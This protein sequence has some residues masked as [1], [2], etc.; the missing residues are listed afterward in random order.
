MAEA[1]WADDTDTEI[2]AWT[3]YEAL[4]N[5]AFASSPATLMCTYDERSFPAEVIADARRTHPQLAYGS[6]ATASPSYRKPEDFL[7]AGC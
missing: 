4:V 3:R 5:L 7:L 6:D 2:A 1:A